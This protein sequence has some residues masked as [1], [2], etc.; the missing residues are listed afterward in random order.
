[1]HTRALFFYFARVKRGSKTHP[2]LIP[3]LCPSL[4]NCK[5]KTWLEL[6]STVTLN[7]LYG[8]FVQYAI[9]PLKF[10]R[11]K[12]HVFIWT[13]CTGFICPS[14]CLHIIFW[15]A[16]SAEC[17]V[18]S[19]SLTLLLQIQLW[20]VMSY[21][22]LPPPLFHIFPLAWLTA[23]VDIPFLFFCSIYV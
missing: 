14:Y 8:V 13:V 6:K 16:I 9:F 2:F 4:Y 17:Q 21:H 7:L 3:L 18:G 10:Q 23:F 12:K 19:F 5:K 1:M 11:K 15:I 22:L 20:L